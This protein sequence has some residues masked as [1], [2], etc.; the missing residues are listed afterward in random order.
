MSRSPGDA[1]I[2]KPTNNVYTGLLAVGVAIEIIALIL[3]IVQ[4]NS[5]FG[6][7]LFSQ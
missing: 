1:I 7:T 4:F 2:V 5:L 3:V 6:K